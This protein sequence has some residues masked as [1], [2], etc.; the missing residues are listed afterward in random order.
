MSP[1]LG[2]LLALLALPGC[3]DVPARRPERRDER[4]E[5][6]LPEPPAR[7]GDPAAL[8]REQLGGDKPVV[9]TGPISVTPP[10]DDPQELGCFSIRREVAQP[11]AHSFGDFGDLDRDGRPDIVTVGSMPS[12]VEVWLGTPNGL[13]A[14]SH[15]FEV[16]DAIASIALADLDRD[17]ILDLIVSDS[18]LG[19]VTVHR[20]AGDGTFTAPQPAIKLRKHVGRAIAADFTGDRLPELAVPVWS[21][22]ML[23]K[24]HRGAP[25]PG[26]GVLRTGQAPEGGLAVD[27]DRDGRL[28]LAVPSNDDHRV[29]VFMSSGPGTF[30]PARSYPCG[31]GGVHVAAAELTGDGHLDLALANYHSGDV[32]LLRGDGRGGFEHHATLPVGRVVWAVRIVDIT[33]DERLDLVTV[34][35]HPADA[36][37]DPFFMGDGAVV[38]HAGDGKG[39]FAYHST[40]R[41]GMS[42]GELW[43]ADTHGDGHLDVVTLNGNGRSITV[44]TGAA[45]EP[46]APLPGPEYPRFGPLP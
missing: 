13:Y 28:D 33:G 29:D 25:R 3:I 4:V 45:C 26:L 11:A 44:L 27:L 21:S 32:C 30:R 6:P 18:D 2:G 22:L 37:K 15:R 16:C 1:R 38:V 5:Q 24:N 35:W 23:L 12:A 39:N 42:P 9:A 36:P 31:Q 20:G 19:T 46:R 8:V 10:P 40:A 14:S 17:D 41:V 43:I 7:G 34:A